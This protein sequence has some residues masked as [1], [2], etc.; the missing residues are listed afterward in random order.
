MSNTS[1]LGSYG[2]QAGDALM[3]RNRILNGA[4]VIDQR[5][6]GATVA[7]A[8]GYVVDRFFNGYFGGTT[9]RFSAQRSTTAPAGFSNS[10]LLTTTTA[11]ASLGA[12]DGL[13][14]IQHIEGF[15]VSDLAFGTANAQT[16]T[17]S[18]W[19]RSSQ[20]GT[21][22]VILANSAANRTYGALVTINSANTFEYKTVT[23][24][25]DIT[26][27]WATDNTA[28]ISLFVGLGGGS[29]R[30]ISAG[31]STGLGGSNPGAVTGQTINLVA[32]NGATLYIT[33]VQLEAGPTATPF[34]RRPYS[35]EEQMCFRYYYVNNRLN[36]PAGGA[37]N[38]RLLL[39][40]LSFNM[41]MV[42]AISVA[43]V[44]LLGSGVAQTT[45]TWAAR[46]TN[47]S[48]HSNETV[49]TSGADAY[50]LYGT[51]YDAEL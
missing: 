17:V 44:N 9:G 7:N 40:G 2:G 11:Q 21:L 42:P 32:V 4:M 5:N 39:P 10:L 27:T 1:L 30:T 16:V 22:G 26:G 41:R 14:I 18:F 48:A 49:Y 45:P 13:G 46:Q 29:S 6:S 25:G 36:I 28:G 50:S 20:T 12:N 23:I 47:G 33:G 37:A 31:W 34:E 19:I 15:N 51:K 43:S 35:V 8:N 38:N 3:F 24:P